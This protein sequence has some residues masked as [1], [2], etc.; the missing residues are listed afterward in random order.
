MSQAI[1]S[2]QEGFL[3][4]QC[5]IN[6]CAN[7]ECMNGGICQANGNVPRCQCRPGTTGTF[8]EQL[9]C[10]PKCEQGGTCELTGNVPVC[11]CPSGTFGINCNII[12]TC[13]SNDEACIEYDNDARCQLDSDNFAL[14]SPI[15]VNATYKCLCLN[16]RSEWTDCKLSKRVHFTTTST[17]IATT[18]SIPNPDFITSTLQPKTSVQ[19]QTTQH[20][21]PLFQNPHLSNLFPNPFLLSPATDATTVSASSVIS[22]DAD[23]QSPNKSGIQTLPPTLNRSVESLPVILPTIPEPSESPILDAKTHI[24]ILLTVSPLFITPKSSLQIHHHLFNMTLKAA[25]PTTVVSSRHPE[26]QDSGNSTGLTDELTSNPIEENSREMSN[27]LK[28]ENVSA[29]SSLSS[30]AKEFLATMTSP[31]MMTSN[32]SVIQLSTLSELATATSSTPKSTTAII[33]GDSSVAEIGPVAPAQ[34]E[35]EEESISISKISNI[36]KGDN[37]SDQLMPTTTSF[38]STSKIHMEE[39]EE[40]EENW[41]WSESFTKTFEE[42]EQTTMNIEDFTTE[43]GQT[44]DEDEVKFVKLTV[45]LPTTTTA[46]PDFNPPS[47][48]AFRD[49]DDTARSDTSSWTIVLAIIFAL[50]VLAG[51]CTTLV[52]RYVRRSRKLHGK[53]NPAREESIL[54]SSYSMPMATVTKEERLI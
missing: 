7:V 13:T 32:F 12:D 36:T 23:S 28:I 1:C 8:C 3:G 43:S 11:R 50:I 30:P 10:N 53:Y 45:G 17:T 44:F 52:F 4:S 47:D 22:S 16:E 40:R 19:P 14:I 49:N 25:T 6:L 5:E 51:A 42:M 33:D 2:C 29:E 31:E 46:I 34:P 35:M 24:P 26:S 54:S 37:L 20:I 9:L 15:P 38:P 39:E 21:A 48:G 27:K 18:T 41:V